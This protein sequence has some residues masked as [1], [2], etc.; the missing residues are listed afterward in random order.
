M[1]EILKYLKKNGQRL[2]SEIAAATGISI[3]NVRRHIADLSAQGEI[4]SCTV[5]RFTDEKPVESV[6]CRIAGY[7]P[8]SSPG[9]K[10]KGSVVVATDEV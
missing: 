5:T 9:R 10:A 4:T 3:T 2:D 6:L 7:I 1:N 8:P